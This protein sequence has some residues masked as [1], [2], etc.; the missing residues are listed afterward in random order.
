MYKY[1]NV[2][3]AGYKGHPIFQDSFKTLSQHLFSMTV[4]TN[5]IFNL[6]F[7]LPLQARSSLVVSGPVG[8]VVKVGKRVFL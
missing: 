3:F 8:R 6:P 1:V 5:L 2:S 7:G 4:I